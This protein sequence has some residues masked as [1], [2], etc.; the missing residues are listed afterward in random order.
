M[1]RAIVVLVALSSIVVAE[2]VSAAGGPSPGVQTGW[3]GI[4]AGSVRYVALP[5]GASTAVAAIRVSDG[6]VV[7]YATV[8]GSFGV[9][10]VSFDGQAGGLSTDGRTLVLAGFAPPAAKGA[11]TEFAVLT[12]RS[13]KLRRHFT[14]NGSFAYDALSPDGST[15]YVLEYLTNAANARYRVRAVDLQR[16]RLLPG[17]IVDRREPDEQMHGSPV[18]RATGTNG[19]WAYTLYGRGA[20]AP[21]VHALD[22]RARAAFCIDLPWR[23][24]QDAL[25]G[26]RMN[27][28]RD[29]RLLLLRQPRVG[30]LAEIDTTTWKVRVLRRPVAARG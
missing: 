14:L 5:T 16:G 1:R 12:P 28:S 23:N 4:R 24:T 9:P 30:R 27:V 2:A 25:F 8:P 11:T 20:A 7:R 3:D 22:T 13:L 6:R 15:M 26:V 18:T 19:R 29:G 21:F 17:S 10:L